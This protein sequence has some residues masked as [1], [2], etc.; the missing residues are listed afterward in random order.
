M[1]KNDIFM[2]P[3]DPAVGGVTGL[4]KLQRGALQRHE[5]FKHVMHAL[6][7]LMRWARAET[8]SFMSKTLGVTPPTSKRV[9]QALDKDLPNVD[10]ADVN[11]VH[12]MDDSDKEFVND[13]FASI[14]YL[15][16]V[17]ALGCKSTAIFNYLV[18]LYSDSCRFD[19]LAFI[20]K[21]A[22]LTPK[23]KEERSYVI[24]VLFTLYIA[25]TYSYSI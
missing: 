2:E 4:S 5:R 14:T 20:V 19:P 13:R 11:G 22:M 15:E 12:A 23:V 1:L 8:R 21:L 24:S 10:N 6:E 25:F 16:G 9:Q 3:G 18:S 7:R 17:I